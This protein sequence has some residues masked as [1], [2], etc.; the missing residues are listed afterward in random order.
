[1]AFKR[2]EYTKSWERDDPDTGF[3]RY[4]TSETQVRKDIQF[5]HDEVKN[6]INDGFMQE[7]ESVGSE[8]PED[9]SGAD[10]IGDKYEGTVGATLA[11]LFARAAANHEDILSLAGGGVPD[12]VK[13]SVVDFTAE[14]WAEIDG[15]YELRILHSQHKRPGAG[16]GCR[17]CSES[18]GSTWEALCTDVG[19]DSDTQDIVLT[20]ENPYSG[21]ITVFGV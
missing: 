2:L 14:G 11:A 9:L 4:E 1:M 18:G 7:L 16:F 17:L 20:A 19:Y 15:G 6:F 12:V 10:H 3:I 8:Q 21:T 13:S 5:L